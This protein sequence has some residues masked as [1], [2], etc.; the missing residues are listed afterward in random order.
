MSFRVELAGP[1]EAEMLARL[2]GDIFIGGWD[3]GAMVSLLSSPGAAGLLARGADGRPL[4]LLLYRRA[5]AEVEI[6]TLGVGVAER[7]RGIGRALVEAMLARLEGRGVETVFLEVAADNAA[8]RALYKRNGF[9][10]AG[11]R[12]RH[13]KRAQGA[14]G[15]LILKRHL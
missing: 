9:I 5:A 10:K 3:A 2:H 13:T 6:L 1:A 7:R 15:A 12:E 8:A 4:G 11:R 14:E